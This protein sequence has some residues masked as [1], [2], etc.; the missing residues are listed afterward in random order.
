MIKQDHFSMIP[1]KLLLLFHLFLGLLVQ[2]SIGQTRHSNPE[3]F[4]VINGL[5]NNEVRCIHKDSKGYIWVGTLYGLAKYDGNKFTVF[6]H[7]SNSN[8]I[9]GDVITV[10]L[11]DNKGNIL[12]GANGLSILERKTGLWKNYLHNPNDKS[13]ISNPGILSIAQENDSTYWIITY[14]GINRFNI[15]TGRFSTL[16]FH[17]NARLFD[18]KIVKIIPHKSILYRIASTFYEYDLKTNTYKEF[19]INNLSGYHNI[20]TF[21]NHILGIRQINIDT[22]SFE[23]LDIES[24]NEFPILNIKNCECSLFSDNENLFIIGNNKLYL[25]NSDL[26]AIDNVLFQTQAIKNKSKI[27]YLCGLKEKNGTIWIGTSE[28]LLKIPPKTPFHILESSNGMPNKYIRSLTVNTNNDLLV[29]V[30]QGPIYKIP[31]ADCILENRT[32]GID[33]IKFP[34]KNGTAYATNQILELKNRNILFITQDTIYHY[35]TQLGIF[36][37]KLHVKNNKQYFSALEIPNGVLIG[38]LEKPRLF[39][40]S[41]QSDK[42]SQD[43]SFKVKNAP[44]VVYTIYKDF[45]NQIWIG[46]EGL[47]K[48][49]FPNDSNEAIVETAIASIN[50]TNY[51]NNSVWNILEIDKDRLM[52]GTTSNGFYVY[53][54]KSDSY[55]HFDRNNGLPTDF[56]CAVLKDH[57]NN[58][59]MSTKDGLSFIDSKDYS[60]K[61]YTVKS[62]PYSC[63]FNFKCCTKTNNNIL[64]FGS[65]QGIVYFNPDS[66]KRDTQTYPLLIN[67]F[68]VFD[69]V[70]RR[71][72][73]NQDTIVLQHNENFFSF[74]FSLLD[75]RNPKEIHYRYQLINYNKQERNVTDGSNLASYTNVPPG[76]YIFRLVAFNSTDM[77]NQQTIEVVI[78]IQPAFYQTTFF[79]A[80]IILLLIGI[81][82]ALLLF[83]IRR[84]ILRGQLY[85]MELDLL[86]AQINPHFIFNTLT[87]IQ[88]TILMS[89]KDVAADHLAKFSRLMRMCLD[90]SRMDY[91]PLEK[92]LQFYKTYVTVESVNLD[93]KIDFQVRLDSTIDPGKIEISPMLIQPFIENAIIHGLSPKN[94]DMQLILSINRTNTVLVCTIQDNGIGR[95]KATAFAKNKLN[96]HKSMGIEISRKSILLLMKNKM[97]T[98]DSISIADNYDKNG[99]PNGTTV[100]LRIPFKLNG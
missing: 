88:H 64:F 91:I 37:D 60:I 93:E 95:E 45:D 86:R 53:D 18:S 74:D 48:L 68:R 100:N 24:N 29:G 46:G 11:E 47:Y 36:T 30:K 94:K 8:S 75:F 84:Q 40:I 20:T 42:I 61:N 92:A 67:E 66:I 41:I 2:V 55:Q 27:E 39:K 9:S 49:I 33:S 62:G 51:T 6:K 80:S 56:T 31:H 21:N 32:N 13:T 98:E 57:N 50:E 97:L 17:P 38:S 14:N 4:S 26:K 44:D 59:W 81:I 90:Y 28:G 82:G 99:K 15:N 22:Y 83:Y 87:S 52:V 76:K 70:V 96:S 79:K 58:F 1:G 10:I 34:Y 77:S 69:N 23:K 43:T 3:E 63:D 89:N 7:E 12:V 25:F 85:K 19:P 65:K 54:K 35:N 5:P 78:I 72:L 16:N 71:E 73:S